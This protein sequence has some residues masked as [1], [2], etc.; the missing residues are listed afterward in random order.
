MEASMLISYISIKWGAATESPGMLAIW[1]LRRGGMETSTRR[2]AAGRGVRETHVQDWPRP[3]GGDSSPSG[4]PW[5]K[6]T[7]CFCPPPIR[8]G[9]CAQ[10]D[11]L[12]PTNFIEQWMQEPDSAPGVPR[13]ETLAAFTDRG[14]FLLQR[15]G[16]NLALF[17]VCVWLVYTDTLI[18]PEHVSTPAAN[19]SGSYLLVRGSTILTAWAVEQKIPTAASTEL[20]TTYGPHPCSPAKRRPW[21]WAQLAWPWP[22]RLI[23]PPVSRGTLWGQHFWGH[24][25]EAWPT[26]EFTRGTFSIAPQTI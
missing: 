15:W 23:P 11:G 26:R 1:S 3:S 14:K 7:L 4:S 19:G 10:K 20:S 5:M 13:V 16:Q 25:L 17:C 9:P 24:W 22:T 2:G 18:D 6:P 21:S 8:K 12:T